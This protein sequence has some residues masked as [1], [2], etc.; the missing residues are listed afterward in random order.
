MRMRSLT[1]LVTDIPALKDYLGSDEICVS[2]ASSKSVLIQ[3][4][5]SVTERYLLDQVMDALLSVMPEAVIAG[6]TSVGEIMHG[7]LSIG[8]IVLSISFFD[9]TLVSAYTVDEPA[10]RETAAGEE[11]MDRIVHTEGYV[12]GVLMLATAL[13]MDISKLFDGMALVPF[14]FPVFGGSAGV[15]NP[16]LKS[17]IFLGKKYIEQG[18]I[19]VVLLGE[20][21]EIRTRTFLGW[22]PLSKELTVTEADGLLLKKI[23]GERAFDVYNRYLDIPND[24]NFFSKALEFPILVKRNGEWIA[25]VPFFADEDGSIGFL[26]DIESG[27]KFHIGYGDP[28]S[29][30]RNSYDVQKELYEF[31]P[32]SIFIYACICRR[33]LMQNSVNLETESFD[34]IAP[35]AGFYTYGEFIGSEGGIHLL[36]STIVIAAFREGDEKDAAAR[37]AVPGAKNVFGIQEEDPFSNKHS[38]IVARLLHFIRVITSE[39]ESA[40][41]E[42]KRLSGIDKLTQAD[43]RQRLD[44]VLQEELKRNDRYKTGLSAIMLDLDHFKDIN[45]NYGHPVGDMVLKEIAGILK[46]NVRAC[47]TAGRWGGEEFLIILPQTDL[48]SAMKAAEK[49]RSAV[50][51]TEFPVAGHVTCSFGVAT[52]RKEDDPDKLLSRADTAM[53]DAKKNG[54][55]RV[56]GE[57]PDT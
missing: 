5:P 43:N 47:D 17:M 20:E 29:I 15:Y 37:S 32:Q 41:S 42:L 11:L 25:R 22:N 8:T 1:Y 50:E 45:D 21:L 4:F 38:R 2:A 31:V 49:I 23:D 14:N 54:R 36:N 24:E 13:S 40:N 26:A 3:I 53:Y 51:K 30:L 9:D 39:L 7:R 12:A 16:N 19:A 35:T 6:S 55:N 33:F 56:V 57:M 44:E 48:P 18:A 28:D 46:S 34:L 52:V 10:G 27:E